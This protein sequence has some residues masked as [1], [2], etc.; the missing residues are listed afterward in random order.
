[1]LRGVSRLD[2]IDKAKLVKPTVVLGRFDG[3]QTQCDQRNHLC[4]GPTNFNNVFALFRSYC[5]GFDGLARL[6]TGNADPLPVLGY[7]TE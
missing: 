4:K 1:M 2:Y 6:P 3:T 5:G 7:V